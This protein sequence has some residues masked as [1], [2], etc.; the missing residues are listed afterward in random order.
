MGVNV[1]NMNKHSEESV[2]NSMHASDA[3]A[4]GVCRQS[5][6]SDLSSGSERSTS[7]GHFRLGRTSSTGKKASLSIGKLYFEKFLDKA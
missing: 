5:V 2:V 3:D 4:V 1:E 6:C 7:I